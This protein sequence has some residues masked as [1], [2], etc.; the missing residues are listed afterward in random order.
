MIMGFG[1]KQKLLALG[2]AIVLANLLVYGQTT[3]FAPVHLDEPQ[4]VIDQW[5]YLKADGSYVDA[6][7]HGAFRFGN[8]VFYRPVL[9]LSL[10]VDAR[11]SGEKFDPAA[12]H[13][14]NLAIHGANAL[15]CFALLVQL[16]R[17]TGL[18]AAG[19]LL[20][21][22]HPGLAAA[23]G[24]I[25]GRN[26][27]LLFTFTALA[28]LFLTEAARRR[29]AALFMLHLIAFFIALLTKETA[30]ALLPLFP[31]WVYVFAKDLTPPGR[32]RLRVAAA[33][34]CWGL[35]AVAYLALR[36][37]ALKDAPAIPV[38]GLHDL[39]FRAAAYAAYVFLPV[40]VP[41]F[42][43][44]QDLSLTRVA[45]TAAVGLLLL[46]A[47]WWRSG[48]K[49]LIPCA[50]AA[51]VLFIIPSAFSDRFLPHR[52]YLPVFFFTLAATEAARAVSPA[53]KA[54]PLALAAVALCFGGLT[55]QDLRRF[56]NPD[57]FWQSVNE[58]SPS[59]GE[60]LYELGYA[61]QMRADFA[62]A[63][64][65]YLKV[66]AESPAIL[67]AR[68]NLAI[69]Y[70]KAGRYDEALMLYEEE[71]KLAPGR[72]YV[73]GN[74]GNLMV[75]KGDCRSAVEYYKRQLVAEP[76]IRKT[77]DNLVSCLLKIGDIEAATRYQQ[78]ALTL[79]D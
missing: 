63:Q 43:W 59:C 17:G 35:S 48:R 74:I 55:A 39:L 42:A 53:K 25:P 36:M 15:L 47:A 72:A 52:L 37:A 4:L 11:L 8:G 41:V 54:A 50:V 65:Y 31:A 77:Y 28:L 7:R 23:S 79:K 26:D 13:R 29:S 56:K 51:G 67:D 60:A 46:A 16:A 40:G 71:L 57:V 12:F 64:R 2:A 5:Q 66:I 19:A 32:R 68:N 21:S 27:S 62:G 33:V 9:T 3:S 20:F 14:G 1:P 10:M 61:A 76:G 78:I 49:G 22:L 34:L 6:F 58:N 45:L 73:I 75:A 44:F 18:A 70:K 30:V 24:W 38:P 69:I